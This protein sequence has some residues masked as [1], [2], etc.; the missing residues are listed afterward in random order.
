MI[1]SMAE[2]KRWYSTNA[3]ML[4]KLSHQSKQ[5]LAAK[6][7]VFGRGAER[8][9]RGNLNYIYFKLIFN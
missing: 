9:I 5:L 7:T 2:M 6:D 1:A 3:K 8:G 4:E